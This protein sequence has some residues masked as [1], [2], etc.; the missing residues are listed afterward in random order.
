LYYPWYFSSLTF[1]LVPKKYEIKSNKK[2]NFNFYWKKIF[3][4]GGKF[5]FFLSKI[6]FSYKKNVLLIVDIFFYIT[7]DNEKIQSNI[8]DS[9]FTV[10]L[11]KI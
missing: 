9:L 1:F 6:I 7:K 10:K 4:K 8:F 3:L 5:C 2:I 11:G